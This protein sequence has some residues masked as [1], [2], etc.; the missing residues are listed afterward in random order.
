MISFNDNHG[1]NIALKGHTHATKCPLI[2]VRTLVIIFI[3]LLL[4]PI[5]FYFTPCNFLDDLLFLAVR[6][7]L[8]ENVE[9]CEP[10]SVKRCH[11]KPV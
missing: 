10:A 8:S 9:N 4:L 1:I 5:F 11:L 3:P 6:N 7:I 2:R